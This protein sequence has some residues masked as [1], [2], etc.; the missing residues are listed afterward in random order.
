MYG[1]NTNVAILD[2]LRQQ[3]TRPMVRLPTSLL[4]VLANGS[5]VNMGGRLCF[6]HREWE[7]R[8]LYCYATTK[9]VGWKKKN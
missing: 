7:P 5:R 2:R 3:F 6:R 1:K 9:T 8:L 4:T